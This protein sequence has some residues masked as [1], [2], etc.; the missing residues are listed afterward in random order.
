LLYPTL[1]RFGW[2]EGAYGRLPDDGLALRGCRITNAVRCVPPENRPTPLEV[3]TCRRF[4]I[5]EI[6]ALRP[7]LRAILALGAVA[8]GSVIAALGQRQKDFPFAHGAEHALPCGLI[9]ADSYHC[10][11]YN[12]NTGRLTPA[13]F[14]AVVGRLAQRLA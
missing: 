9:L 6:E 14:E 11:R 7:G 12:T 10:S 3:R 13:M 4:L 1:V 2:A 5:Q 8:H